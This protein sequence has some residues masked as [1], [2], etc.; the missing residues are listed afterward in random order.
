MYWCDFAKN[1]PLN[2]LSVKNVP[3]KYS[4]KTLQSMMNSRFSQQWF[5]PCHVNTQAHQKN[6]NRTINV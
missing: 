1:K 6:S 2:V 5:Y 3:G 4:P